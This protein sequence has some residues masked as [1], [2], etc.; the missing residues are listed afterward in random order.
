MGQELKE[1][2][3]LQ[4]GVVWDGLWRKDW[5]SQGKKQRAWYEQGAKGVCISEWSGTGKGLREKGRQLLQA[6]V[7]PLHSPGNDAYP[8]G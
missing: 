3:V 4:A 5:Q 2:G 7:R 8:P 1:E 6:R